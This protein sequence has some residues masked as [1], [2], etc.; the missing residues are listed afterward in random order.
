[1]RHTVIGL[2][3]TYAQAE[4]ARNIL[5]QTGFASSDIELQANPETPA[6]ATLAESPG[7]IANI[8]RFLSSLFTTSGTTAPDAERYTQAVR[9]G[10]V[11]VAV[12]VESE[13]HADLARN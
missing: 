6:D 12:S 11:V 4:S 3:D 5:V 7:V 13:P 8:E 9:R 10:A 2:F 1:M